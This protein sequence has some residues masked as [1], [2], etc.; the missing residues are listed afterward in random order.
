MKKKYLKYS[1]VGFLAVSLLS[2]CDFL[3][4]NES[5]FYS[6]E[7]IITNYD[8]TRNLATH[9]YSFLPNGFCNLDGAMQDAGTDD[10]V[11]VYMTSDVQRFVDGTWSANRTIDDVWGHYYEGIRAAN[12]YLE[13]AV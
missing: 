9:V 10:A 13:V 11:H 8:R 12:L 7:D 4:C 6:E 5:Q 3:D 2:G 1:L